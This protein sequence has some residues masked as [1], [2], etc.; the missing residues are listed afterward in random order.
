MHREGLALR[1]LLKKSNELQEI[2][3]GLYKNME[4]Q[5]SQGMLQK[6]NV[7]IKIVG[8]YNF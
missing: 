6:N 7:C 5:Q 1:P 8:R 2:F 4:V 3:Q